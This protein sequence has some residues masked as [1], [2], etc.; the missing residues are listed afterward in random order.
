MRSPEEVLAAGRGIVEPVMAAHGFV[1]VAGA[2]GQSSGGT[3]ASGSF[4]RGN[5]CLELNFRHS[6][7]LVA[8]HLGDRS[9][10]HAAYMRAVLGVNGGNQYPGFS[11]DPID[12]FR[13][14]AHDLESFCQSFLSGPDEEFN[15]IA[16]STRPNV[17][18][19]LP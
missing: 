8:Y 12:G 7:G 19:R 14:L 2:E 1:W 3:F 4:V 18:K 9:V 16:S 17:R 10:D 11:S 6:L 15:V 13:H 5:R